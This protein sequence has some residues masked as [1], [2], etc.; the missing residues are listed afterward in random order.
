M[1]LEE[2]LRS[3]IL[4]GPGI[5]ARVYW[6]Q[7]PQAGDLPAIVL[8]RITG[9][10]DYHMQGPS[11]LVESRVQADVWALGY[12]D[13][14]FLARALI[15]HVSGFRGTQGTTNF[16]AIM[17]DGERDLFEGGSNDADRYFRVSIDLMIQH[18]EVS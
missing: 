1:A 17:I 7:R 11:G 9:L 6:V 10:P 14:K 12:G 2:D 16:Q 13:A 3:L 18:N 8:Q 15:D 4:A 5:P